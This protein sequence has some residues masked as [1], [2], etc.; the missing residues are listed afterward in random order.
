M[1]HAA[2][3]TGKPAGLLALTLLFVY[4]HVQLVLCDA[5][6]IYL[7]P[8]ISSACVDNIKMVYGQDS[9]ELGNLKRVI[10]E[11]SSKQEASMNRVKLLDTTNTGT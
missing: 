11:E 2:N 10:R 3:S 8:V 4:L 7:L 1:C 5:E 6:L 9:P